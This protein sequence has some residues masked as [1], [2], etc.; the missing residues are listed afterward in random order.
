MGV[1]QNA[2]MVN[3]PARSYLFV[4]G[5]RPDRFGKALA[6]G[7][8]AVVIDWEDA[9]PLAETAAARMATLSAVPQLQIAGVPWVLRIHTPSSPAGRDDL[10]LLSQPCA[11]PLVSTL[12]AVMVAKTES[13]A[14]LAAVQLALRRAG[15]P[16]PLLPL[17]ESAAGWAALSE[18]TR[19]AS[20]QR[21]VFGHLDFQAD[22]GIACDA[23]ERE[24]DP[25][26]LA[27]TLHSRLAG[28][29]PPV[30]GVTTSWTDPARLQADVE[31]ARRFG[32]G[33]KLC[34]HP[35]QVEGVHQAFAPTPEQRAWAQRVLAADAA[36]AGAAV[37]LDGKMVDAPVV[38][39]ARRVLAAFD[40][41]TD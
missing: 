40:R 21:L 25:V 10:S 23:E 29:E 30:D 33:A 27:I 15:H 16:V 8:D 2:G 20:V 32:F 12:S 37:Q 24:L 9:V 38:L 39:Q 14:Q 31:R 35:Q 19:H 3:V 36:S 11:A 6:S 17:I 41:R 22:T 1:D 7:A 18:L 26:R 4:P 13:A 34:I 28:L 5:H